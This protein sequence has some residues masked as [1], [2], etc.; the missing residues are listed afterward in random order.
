MALLSMD[1]M[2]QFHVED[3]AEIHVGS[4]DISVTNVVVAMWVAVLV[5]LVLLFIATSRKALV[6]GRGQ[7]I[8][9]I[10]Y[11]FVADMIRSTAGTEGLR[12]FPFVFSIF[13]FVLACNMLGMIPGFFTAT[14][15]VVVTGTLAITV[16]FTVIGY[17]IYKNGFKFFKLFA[18]AGIPWPMLIFISPIE[19]LSFFSRPLS[20]SLRLFANM[21]GGHTVLKVF[22]G[23]VVS[24]IGMSGLA[25][26]G[27]LGPFLF[28]IPLL[29]LEL[30]VAFLQ[31]YV[32]AILT[33]I[34]LNDSL[35]PAH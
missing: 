7:S 21:L 26:L 13:I 35:H 14:S 12:F 15:Q 17:G 4:L 8:A 18:P 32:F 31:A 30:L 5:T 11:E 22:A 10:T 28:T 1:P 2:H 25:S 3:V 16:F 27:A 9:E 33:C 24:I 23:F 19:V 20:H 29:A 34:Y 6:P